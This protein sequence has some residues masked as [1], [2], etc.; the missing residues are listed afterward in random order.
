MTDSSKT[1]RHS[2]NDPS[3]PKAGGLGNLRSR[4]FDVAD[5]VRQL[6][7]EISPI[8]I[9][10]VRQFAKHPRSIGNLLE[11]K[12]PWLNRQFL[13]VAS[14]LIEPF[15]VGMGLKVERLGEEVVEV[16]MPGMWRNQGDGGDIHNGALLSLGEF[17][18]RLFWEYHLDVRRNEIQTKRVQ[19]RTLVR[20]TGDMKAVFRLPVSEREAILHRIR[21]DGFASIETQTFIYDPNGRLVAEV[22]VD[23]ELRRQLSLGAPQE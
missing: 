22:E 20:A 8:V 1:S 6:T 18:V 15:L 3:A 11:A 16:K 21:A 4:F 9:E 7:Q 19:L 5:R 17:A 13:G 2:K 23:W 12:S 10:E 14:N